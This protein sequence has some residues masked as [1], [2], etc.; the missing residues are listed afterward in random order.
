MRLAHEKDV[1]DKQK[2]DA[3]SSGKASNV[4]L[5]KKLDSFR[6]NFESDLDLKANLDN[7]ALRLHSAG[8]RE[9]AL[10]VGQRAPEFEIA[11]MSGHR[12]TLAQLRA[13]GPLALVFYRGLW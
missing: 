11:D 2:V 13:D 5:Q 7:E 9:R 3:G 12:V 8:V 10:Q 1:H 4:E 6:A